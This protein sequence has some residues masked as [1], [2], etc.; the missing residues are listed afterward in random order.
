VENVSLFL[1]QYCCCCCS[2]CCCCC[3]WCCCNGLRVGGCICK[4]VASAHARVLS[5]S[6]W[7][8]SRLPLY[9]E[10]MIVPLHPDF[11][12]LLRAKNRFQ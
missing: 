4:R 1:H 10:S 2:C 5:G 7:S 9:I 3:C 8:V 12:F 11:W 6:F